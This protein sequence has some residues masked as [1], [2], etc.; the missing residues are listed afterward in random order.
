MSET[1][2]LR[3]SVRNGASFVENVVLWDAL[4][5][6]WELS[7]TERASVD[8]AHGMRCTQ[9]QSNLRSI[10]L[11]GTICDVLG[12]PQS[13][14]EFVRLSSQAVPI[15]VL[16]INEA[17]DLSPV[18]KQMPGHVLAEYPDADMQALS[19]PDE[20]FD[21]VVHSDTIEHVARPVEALVECRRV[22]RPGGSVCFT[23][24]TIVGRLTRSR[25]G[26]PRRFHGWPTKETDDYLVHTEFGADMW[27]TVIKAGFTAVKIHTISFPDA[28]AM[29]ARK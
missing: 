26:L 24:P 9:C 3:C 1:K 19:C 18:L 8:R 25:T 28:V 29:S 2:G 17:G 4:V 15:K 21:L 6:E 7:P 22:L 5:A 10:A 20:A 27:T 23:V 11:A 14:S 12:T 16:E 13:L